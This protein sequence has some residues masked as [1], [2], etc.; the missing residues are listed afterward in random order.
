VPEDYSWAVPDKGVL[1]LLFFSAPRQKSVADEATLKRVDN[2]VGKLER[3]CGNDC[4]GLDFRLTFFYLL[5]MFLIIWSSWSWLKATRA[6]A[7]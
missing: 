4:W 2:M 1:D 7:K 5:L 3:L 6:K